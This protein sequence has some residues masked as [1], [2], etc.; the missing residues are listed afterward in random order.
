MHKA[1]VNQCT[2]ELNLIPE[3]PILIKSGRQGADPTK[4]DM[5]F[6]ETFHNGRKEI[7]FPGSSLKGAIRAQAERIVRTVGSQSYNL[8]EPDQLW[9]NDPLNDKRDYLKG[10]SP[11]NIYLHSCFTEQMFGNTSIS[12]RV[13]VEDAYYDAQAGI[14]LVLEERNGVAIDRVTGAATD[15]ALFNFEVCTSGAFSTK[16]HLKNFSLAQ[17]GLIGLVLRDLNDGWF[18]IG[19]GKSRGLGTVSLDY[20]RAIVRYPTCQFQDDKIQMMGK[21]RKTWDKTMLLGAGEFLGK[22]PY[23]FPDRDHQATPIPAEAMSLGFGVQM[24]W[25]GQ[26]QVE[27]L[28]R[29]AVEQW[30]VLLQERAA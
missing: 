7:Y 2:I 13:R 24:E 15:K 6:V 30:K 29:S 25:R 26:E 10:K 19:F 17:L 5:E 4:P 3:G 23:G 14:P 18:G 28:F 16:I 22:N 27:S 9:A 12:S 11:E 8:K 21:S 20:K 1:I